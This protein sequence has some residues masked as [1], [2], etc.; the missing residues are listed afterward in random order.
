MKLVFE[1]AMILAAGFGKRMLPLT[2]KVPK[3]LV[4]VDNKPLIFHTIDKLRNE[5]VKNILINNLN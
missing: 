2:L 5:K 3:P 4:H 1:N